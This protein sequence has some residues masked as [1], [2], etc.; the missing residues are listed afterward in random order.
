ML[1]LEIAAG[2]VLGVLGLIALYVLFLLGLRAWEGMNTWLKCAAGLFL[3]W[4]VWGIVQ[5]L[6]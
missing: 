2:I 5:E 6:K 4:L 3:V 1:I